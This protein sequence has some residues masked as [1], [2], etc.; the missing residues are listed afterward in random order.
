MG[1]GLLALLLAAGLAWRSQPGVDPVEV[2][3]AGIQGRGY[4][5]VDAR[6]P[7]QYRRNHLAGAYSVPGADP[8]VPTPLQDGASRVVV[9]GDRLAETVKTA[10]ALAAYQSEPVMILLDPP[11]S[12]P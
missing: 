11:L 2:R 8:V 3:W 9:Y 12:R 5:L 7:E 6:G 4:L 10:R 1:L